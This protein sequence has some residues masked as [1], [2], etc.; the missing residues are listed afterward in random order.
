MK[1]ALSLSFNIVSWMFLSE[2]TITQQ[3]KEDKTYGLIDAIQQISSGFSDH[4][5]RGMF[6]PVPEEFIDYYTATP[7]R[8]SAIANRF[9]TLNSYHQFRKFIKEPLFYVAWE[10]FKDDAKPDDSLSALFGSMGITNYV[11]STFP[12]KNKEEY[13]R[14]LLTIK[15]KISESAWKYIQSDVFTG[16]IK[17]L[18]SSDALSITS[19]PESLYKLV[20]LGIEEGSRVNHLTP[21]ELKQKLEKKLAANDRKDKF[22]VLNKN[23]SSEEEGSYYDADEDIKTSVYLTKMGN[24]LRYNFLWSSGDQ[25]NTTNI[26][27]NIDPKSMKTES[28]ESSTHA[29]HIPWS[30]FEQDYDAA[31]EKLSQ[32]LSDIPESTHSIMKANGID[33]D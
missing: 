1:K 4:V 5:L 9:K 20:E 10:Q 31:T 7:A 33:I 18:G 12:L 24:L 25:L 6:E 8:M 16:I 11:L 26:L 21:E 32:A 22:P 13:L 14:A 29:I 27:I 17:K 23:I 19:D 30:D 2:A 15:N 3:S 28:A